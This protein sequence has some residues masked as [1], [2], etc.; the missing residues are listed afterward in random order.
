MECVLVKASDMSINELTKRLLNEG[1]T[2]E[3]PPDWVNDWNDF[4]GGWQ[5]PNDMILKM[6]FETPCGLLIKGSEINNG[7]MSFMGANWTIEND[8]YAVTCPKF[9][10]EP[11]NLNH[12]LLR[13]CHIGHRELLTHCACHLTDKPYNYEHSYK[14]A[15]DDVWAEA[16]ELFKDFER[17]L[18]GRACKARCRYN[19]TTKKWSMHYDPI[20]CAHDRLNCRF[21]KVL[22]KELSPNKGNVYY[23]IKKTWIE[24]GEGFL[25]DIQKT[26]ITKGVK[27]LNRPAS[28]TLCE[29]IIK[30]SKTKITNNFINNRKHAER[31]INPTIRYE[32]LNFRCEV[33]ASRDLLQDLAD[34]Q[35]GIEVHHA[36][37]DARHIKEQK[38]Q[39]REAAKAKKIARSEKFVLTLGY[40]GLDDSEKR[41]AEKLLGLERITELETERQNMFEPIQESLF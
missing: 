34:A 39:R 36:S 37:I 23:D 30:H 5:Y 13:D 15:H 27:L 29:A 33:R 26:S 25:P 22:Q 40:D 8:N 24:T 20:D 3:S 35:E 7:S 9:S 19:R 14:K 16:E 1:Y 4:Y 18:N 31:L 17:Q 10:Q 6:V 11:C 38:H 41:R 21:C 12:E 32:L 2:K 28:V